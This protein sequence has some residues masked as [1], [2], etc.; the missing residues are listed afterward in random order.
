MGRR[1][2]VPRLDPS[3]VASLLDAEQEAA[4]DGRGGHRGRQSAGEGQDGEG[5]GTAAVGRQQAAAAA[6]AEE[7]QENQTDQPSQGVRRWTLVSADRTSTGW[8]AETGGSWAD[9][10]STLIAAAPPRFLPFQHVCYCQEH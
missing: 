8:R 9:S 1:E 6:A 10:Y 3:A 2:P 5:V 7:E 4:A